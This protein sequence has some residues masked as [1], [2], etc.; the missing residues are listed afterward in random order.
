MSSHRDDYTA[1]PLVGDI[2]KTLAERIQAGRYRD[3]RGFP[4]ERELVEEFG[5][6]RT[7]IRK[8][9]ETLAAQGL[10]VRSPR[11]R[12]VVR[13]TAESEPATTET[14][15]RSL[16]LWI[17]PSPTSPGASAIVQGICRGLDHEAYRLVIGDFVRDSL[18]ATLRSEAR[19]LEQMTADQDIAG[20]LLWYFGG[21]DNLPALQKV[22]AAGIPMVFLDRRAPKGFEADYVGVDNE[23]SAEQIVKHLLALGHRRI[24]HITNMDWACT[25]AERL[26]GYRRALEEADIPYDP[27][28][29]VTASGGSQAEA[30]A[31][32]AALAERLLSL[33]DPPT[34]AFAVNDVIADYAMTA[35]RARGLR[36]PNDMSVAG[37]DGLERWMPAEP[38][39]TTAYQPFERLGELAVKVLLQRIES[40]PTAA[41]QHI[42]LEAP[43][44]IHGS[45]Q[46]LRREKHISS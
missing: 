4:S 20:I 1:S 12:T 37:F 18:E 45:T 41:Y 29:V 35:L 36:I 28:L 34:A 13:G 17:W 31:A 46:A 33:P 5:V 25:V 10:V 19:F 16:G 43:L 27:D 40:G 22:R 2:T 24:A 44:H 42:L 6:S 3:R 21:P 38:F 8:A 15:R 26:A 30:R 11:C 23:R 9:I 32:H 39:L 14:R 7:I